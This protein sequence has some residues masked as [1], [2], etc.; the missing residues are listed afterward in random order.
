[1]ADDEFDRARGDRIRKLREERG[2]TQNELGRRT[3]VSRSQ[4]CHYENGSICPNARSLLRLADELGVTTDE[5]LGLAPGDTAAHFEAWLL[6]I[7]PLYHGPLRNLVDSFLRSYGL[8]SLIRRK[9]EPSDP[10]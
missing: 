5:I 10:G 8:G 3:A 9:A 1:M 4:I 6:R 7:P 2:W